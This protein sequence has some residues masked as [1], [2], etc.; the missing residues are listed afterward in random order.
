MRTLHFG[1]RVADLQR[2][3]AFYT[4]VGYE[5][6]GSVPE[7]PFGHLTMLK[8][9]DDEFVTIEL[10]HDPR[11]GE[12]DIGSGLNHFVIQVASMDATT[13]E[14]AASGI[15]ADTP[16]SP[17]GSEDFRTAWITDP[18]GN[19]IELVQ[20]PAGHPDGITAADWPD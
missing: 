11:N 15:D 2:S 18:D 5:V 16:G 14:L 12:V 20:W 19:R 9:P 17:D 8:L 7:T 3:L 13:T 1:L 10:V 4:A 6:V